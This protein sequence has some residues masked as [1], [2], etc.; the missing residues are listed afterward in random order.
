MEET[1]EKLKIKNEVLMEMLREVQ[2][3]IGT[4]FMVIDP[5]KQMQQITPEILVSK[6][7]F[8]LVDS[9]ELK[10]G[11][12]SFLVERKTWFYE[13]CRIVGFETVDELEIFLKCAQILPLI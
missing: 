1:I 5:G 10:R 4:Q 7:G 2:A 8:T 3:K 12:L 9:V 11:F 13:G 6:F